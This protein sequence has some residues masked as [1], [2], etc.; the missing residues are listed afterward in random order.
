MTS[1]FILDVRGQAQEVQVNVKKGVE[2]KSY[3]GVSNKNFLTYQSLIILHY[4]LFL[5]RKLVNFLKMV[6][7]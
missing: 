2:T 7:I 1:N 5:S 6:I 4:N 3:E